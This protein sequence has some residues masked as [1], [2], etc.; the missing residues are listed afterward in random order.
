MV[1]K[2][3]VLSLKILKKIELRAILPKQK[4]IKTC[5]DLTASAFKTIKE[6]EGVVT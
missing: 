2:Q 4:L 6:V 5:V 3:E 1:P